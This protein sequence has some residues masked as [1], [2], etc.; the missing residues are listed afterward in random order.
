MLAFA[1]LTGREITLAGDEAPLRVYDTSGPRDID[2]RGRLAVVGDPE[3]AI[4][5][6]VRTTGG[7]PPDRDPEVGDWLWNELWSDDEEAATRLEELEAEL[8]ELEDEYDRIEGRIR[9]LEHLL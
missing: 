5:G 3:G 7:D 8:H 1:S 9:Q 6:V 2:D 4:F